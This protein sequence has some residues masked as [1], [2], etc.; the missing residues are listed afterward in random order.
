MPST[1]AGQVNRPGEVSSSQQRSTRR[2]SFERVPSIFAV[3]AGRP[4]LG[5]ICLAHTGPGASS[6]ASRCPGR[7][8]AALPAATSAPPRLPRPAAP[9]PRRRHLLGLRR[10][11]HRPAGSLLAILVRGSPAASVG[12]PA[13]TAARTQPPGAPSIPRPEPQVLPPT[14][15]Y[16]LLGLDGLKQRPH[17][18]C[19]LQSGGDLSIHKPINVS[20]GQPIPRNE[21]HSHQFQLSLVPVAQ[22]SV[23][24]VGEPP[25]DRHPLRP[26]RATVHVSAPSLLTVH[27]SACH[28]RERRFRVT[29]L[30]KP[31]PLFPPLSWNWSQVA[32]VNH[33]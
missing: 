10:L 5:A 24:G 26:G 30:T 8:A 21:P 7:P 29:R 28:A 2:F 20:P 19:L 3:S 32:H 14:P 18:H 22:R 6:T 33:V 17:R 27:C 4:I 13:R 25:L 11:S 31:T 1:G 16:G 9:P 12:S 23:G 15:D